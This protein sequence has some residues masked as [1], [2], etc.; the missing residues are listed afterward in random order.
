MHKFVAAL[1]AGLWV[2]G[3]AYGCAAGG[4]TDTNGECPV[5]SETCPCTTGGACD[6]G[7]MCLS[8]ICVDPN[9]STGGG[10]S[11]TGGSGTGGSGDCIPDGEGCQAVDVIFALDSSGSMQAENGALAATQAFQSVVDTISSINC[12]QVDFRIGI[13]NDNDGGFVSGAATPWFDSAS[14]SNQEIA[15]AFSASA[16]IVIGSESASLGCEHVLTSAVNL[17]V[18]DTTGF[19]REGA[20]LVLVLVTDVDD[21]G[22]YD[23]PGGNA[24]GLGCTASPQ[25]T[26]ALYQSLLTLKGDD[27][28]AIATIVV[29][30]NPTGT[31][32]LGNFCQ[33]PG[34]CGC[35]G[36]ECNAFFATRLWEFAG[37]V[38]DYGVTADICAGAASVPGAV[39]AAFDTQIDLACKELEPPK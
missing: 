1:W 6:P 22:S 27:P 39:Q 19:I 7:L 24:C 15:N 16:N 36:S 38:G 17:A 21:Y 33:Q 12:G 4:E 23:M 2:A 20:L 28:A 13:T 11:G 5:G 31:P 37:H 14:L 8:N 32:N 3:M 25:P 18:N 10:G 9:N 30:G 29:A 26:Q 34:S 35:N